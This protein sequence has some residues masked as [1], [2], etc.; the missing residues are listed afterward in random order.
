MRLKKAKTYWGKLKQLLCCKS[1]ICMSCRKNRNGKDADA[2]KGDKKEKSEFD[3][4]RPGPLISPE[5]LALAAKEG[6]HQ[7][8][9]SDMN[10]SKDKDEKS[11]DQEGGKA[12]KR[13]KRRRKRGETEK[14]K[15]G[16]V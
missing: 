3:E 7:V 15:G 4:E 1:K 13:G 2:S 6:K 8:E 11:K 9:P 14:P 16:V 12:G 5:A 10:I